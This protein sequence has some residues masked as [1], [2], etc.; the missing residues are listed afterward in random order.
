[1]IH[2]TTLI[3]LAGCSDGN[4]T[5]SGTQNILPLGDSITEGVPFTYRY[6]L[7]NQLSD[8][9]YAFDFVGSH[10]DGGWDYPDEGWDR[11]NEGHSG[12]TTETIDQELSNWL[13]QYDVDIALIHL[14]TNDAGEG[15]VETSHTAMVSI[16]E[17]LR[18]TNSMI[19]E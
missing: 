2:L 1:M 11:D 3:L 19:Y 18:S 5:N 8:E 12:W 7:H 16:V 4:K 17:Q 15:N 9:G 14:G 6:P 13:P 10:T